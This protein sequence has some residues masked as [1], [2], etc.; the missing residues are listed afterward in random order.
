MT[1]RIILSAAALLGLSFAAAP[2]FA[3]TSETNLPWCGLV[4]GDLECV[5]PTL[6]EC[7]R[8]MQPEGQLC[9]PNPRSEE[10]K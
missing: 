1:I 8:W 7:E 3:Q 4:G 2:T 10:K 9:T 5:Y 6:A